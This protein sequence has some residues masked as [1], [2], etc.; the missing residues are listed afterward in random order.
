MSL[1]FGIKIILDDK[2]SPVS[3]D[4][5]LG[6]YNV[7]GD[8]SE[9]RW[10]QSDISG[11]STTWKSGIIVQNGIKRFTK[12]IDLSD[13][14][15][16]SYPGKGEVSVININKFW[17]ECQ[18]R[19][20]VFNGLKLEIWELGTGDHQQ[21]IRT[22]F[23]KEPSWNTKTFKIPFVG[24]HTKRVANIIN[25]VNTIQFPFA[26]QDTNNKSIPA[27]FGKLN[28]II[29][30]ELNK[31]TRSSIAK[32]IRTDDKIFYRKYNDDYFTGSGYI[33]T[34]IFPINS[35]NDPATRYYTCDLHGIPSSGI[36]YY[37]IDNVYVKVVDGTG[38]DQ[39]RKVG[40]L[41]TTSTQLIFKVDDFFETELND[42]GT[43]EGRSWV[44]IIE[45][46]RKYV[47]DHFQCKGFIDYNSI[48]LLNGAEIYTYNETDGIQRIAP[49]GYEFIN[50]TIPKM[51]LSINPIMY[52]QGDLDTQNSFLI[53]PVENLRA[54]NEDGE[55]NLGVWNSDSEG[56]WDTVVPYSI[57]YPSIFCHDI[58]DMDRVTISNWDLSGF[59]NVTDKDK[60]TFLTSYYE[61]D[62]HAAGGVFYKV[63]YFELPELPPGFTFTDCYVCIKM[64][65]VCDDV[66]YGSPKIRLRRFKYTVNIANFGVDENDSQLIYINDLPDF[67]CVDSL[68]TYNENF[69]QVT[70]DAY[71]KAGYTN[72]VFDLGISSREEY[73]TLIQGSLIFDRVYLVQSEPPGQQWTDDSKIYEIAIMFKK[74]S[75]ITEHIYSP[76]QGRVFAYT[77]QGRKTTTDLITKP[78]DLLEHVCRLQNY[79]DTCDP[80]PISNWGL[81]YADEPLIATDGWGSF[82]DP[83]LIS[84]RALDVA[85]QVFEFDQGYTDKLKQGICKELLLANWQDASD[86]ERVIALPNNK[87]DPVYTVQMSDILDRD[88]IKISEISENKI[89]AEPWVNYNKNPATNEFENSIRILHSSASTYSINYVPGALND[90]DAQEL[91]RGCHSLYLR[92]QRLNKPSI[93]QTNL[94]WANGD[95]AYTIAFNY[96]R[97]WINWQFNK[98]IDFPVHYNL[99]ASWQECTPINLLFSHQ[100][101]NISRSALIEKIDMNP[102]PG[103]DMMIRAI[104][105][106]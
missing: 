2:S 77:W 14:G 73:E 48:L 24:S 18:S 1:C 68:D 34:Y 66:G 9:F 42:D 65:T 6:L 82:D 3:A 39:I 8:N 86:Y 74:Q 23:C 78:N 20:I 64:S 32:L 25:I 103:Y 60:T 51:Q 80:P 83:D 96:L 76:I 19:N 89:I 57:N 26:S 44:Q 40:L 10:C 54:A 85:G 15:N 16:S 30:N 46:R 49:Y 106:A 104:M 58:A 11:L 99:A 53:L 102:N 36:T 55:A 93:K 101:N 22:Y 94:Q 43:G 38:T 105:Y 63:F 59:V 56:W 91:W 4:S 71:N 67:Y 100:T 33:E 41:Y 87:L 97:N 70:D 52:D 21:R 88:K 28:P 45:I 84:A 7:T 79:S 95:G 81:I 61:G 47:L 35:A 13:G 69:F 31:M 5:D 98:E 92:V 27:S 29:N 50:T 37:S 72:A 12:E 90:S 75:D 17:Q 62:V